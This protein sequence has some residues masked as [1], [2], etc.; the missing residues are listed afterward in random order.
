MGPSSATFPAIW[1]LCPAGPV[2]PSGP[3][4]SSRICGTAG[5]R[6]LFR[7]LG[8][9]PKIST[10]LIPRFRRLARRRRGCTPVVEGS[11]ITSVELSSSF[12]SGP[13]TLGSCIS[14]RYA[15]RALVA[16]IAASTLS[17]SP[18]TSIVSAASDTTLRRFCCGALGV[19][20]GPLFLLGGLAFLGASSLEGLRVAGVLDAG[21]RRW[22]GG[23]RAGMDAS[24]ELL[25]SSLSLGAEL[26]AL[27]RVVTMAN[28]GFEIGC[29]D[30]PRD[31][32]TQVAVLVD[33]R[34]TDSMFGRFLLAR[35][36]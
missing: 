12:F 4:L 5:A 2:L 30:R 27:R 15:G 35:R 9:P 3:G 10:E 20:L 34:C 32:K 8:E 11:G 14:S 28:G 31:R 7:G 23:V 1:S 29:R 13:R 24:S 18:C 6:L 19:P 26:R 25:S 21:C 36:L 22:T 16:L 17:S 33:W